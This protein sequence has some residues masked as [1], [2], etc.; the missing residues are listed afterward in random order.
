MGKEGNKTLHILF[1]QQAP[2]KCLVLDKIV[3]TLA[4][5]NIERRQRET[6]LKLSYTSLFFCLISPP[7]LFLF[8]V[9]HK[10]FISLNQSISL[11]PQDL[12]QLPL[13]CFTS[14]TPIH[15][16]VDFRQPLAL[17]FK[18]GQ[19]QRVLSLSLF[20]KIIQN[21]YPHRGPQKNV[22]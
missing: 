6:T 12:C 4:F 17:R 15:G 3:H 10:P 20:A 11:Q 5:E 2:V 18:V 8:P 14:P 22:N 19:G 1:S 13:Q 21:I 7:P 16:L 9:I